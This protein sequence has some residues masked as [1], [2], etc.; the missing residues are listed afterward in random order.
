MDETNIAVPKLKL[1]LQA[2]SELGHT[3]RNTPQYQ[4]LMNKIRALSVEYKA[5]VD[6]RKKPAGSN[7]SLRKTN[8]R[9]PGSGESSL[10]VEL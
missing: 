9:E 1:I 6:A 4:T 10:G 2:W 5:L 3:N 8:K 7:K